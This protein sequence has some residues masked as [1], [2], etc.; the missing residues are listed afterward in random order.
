MPM[1]ISTVNA[2]PCSGEYG[3]AMPAREQGVFVGTPYVTRR[4]RPREVTRA[5][6]ST[7]R[8]DSSQ[9]G[10]AYQPLERGCQAVRVVGIDEQSRVADDF[11]QRA[12]VRDDHGNTRRHRLERGYPEPFVERRQ[13]EHLSALVQRFA[14]IAR[15]VAAILDMSGEGRHAQ[16]RR[17]H[18]GRKRRGARRSRDVERSD[19]ARAAARRRSAGR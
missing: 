19:A 5:F 9:I 3:R 11:G 7:S 18:P 13:H 8:T 17:A 15:N 12:T 10:I 14:V 1:R 16:S 4:L 2:R 6:E